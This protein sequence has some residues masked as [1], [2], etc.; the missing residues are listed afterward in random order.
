MKGV[1][2]LILDDSPKNAKKLEKLLSKDP[3]SAA[4][5]EAAKAEA[6]RPA[7]QEFTK[8]RMMVTDSFV[9]FSRIGIGGALIIIPISQITTIYRT[10]VVRNTYDFDSVTL[11]VETGS[12]IRYL[13]VYPRTSA[14]SLDVFNEVIAAVRNRMSANGG[15]QV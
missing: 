2:D 3:G 6:A 4:Y 7:A 5:F 9:C 13:A 10:N 1:K 8:F 15:A 12:Q 11:A 14:K